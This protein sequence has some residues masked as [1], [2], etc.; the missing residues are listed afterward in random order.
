MIES[1]YLIIGSG[2]I[3]VLTAQYLLEKNR[4]VVIIDN[5]FK[6]NK[7][8]DKN[9]NLKNLDNKSFVY[10]FDN[11]AYKNNKK[12]LPISSK[13]TGGFSKVWGGTLNPV[14]K[15]EIKKMGLTN[16]RYFR[17]YNWI[18]KYVPN[19]EFTSVYHSFKQNTRNSLD[20]YPPVLSVDKDNENFWNAEILLNELLIKYKN[21]VR[22]IP[23]IEVHSIDKDGEIFKILSG[24]QSFDFSVKKVYVC[25]GVFSSSQIASRMQKTN[26]FSIS[27]S[28]LAIWPIFY[29]GKNFLSETNS[30]DNLNGMLGKA[31]A[32]LII[33]LEQKNTS[34]KCQLYE[35]S[36][37]SI[38]EIEKRLPILY[39]PIKIFINLL[40]KRLFLLFVYKD[41][42]HSKKGIFKIDKEKVYLDKIVEPKF[43]LSIFKYFTK[44]LKSKF[45]LIPF[46]YQFKTFGSFHSGI[47]NLYK[48]NENIYFDS[49]GQLPEFSNIHFLDSTILNF[50]PSGPFTMSSIV[51]CIATL[52]LIEDEK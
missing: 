52:E 48:N 2:P 22:Y 29:L 27:D 45:L 25:S 1:E 31:Y 43:K 28:D 18:L 20:I 5:S 35:L 30:F 42:D 3:G 51:N 21:S 10:D 49:K 12:I 11:T 47:T 36:D 32:M 44:F 39:K 37:E 33:N 16:E 46:K 38:K 7:S 15:S 26:K 41:S 13:S 34:I 24:N 23:D 9:L 6:K 50:I 40:K 8:V 19:M 4:K 14:S 17:I